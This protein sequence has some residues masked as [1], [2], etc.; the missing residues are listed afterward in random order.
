M[1]E[2][3]ATYNNMQEKISQLQKMLTASEH[4]RRVLQERLEAARQ[5]VADVKK[6]N[7]VLQEKIQGMT[8][9]NEDSDVRR[10]EIENQLKSHQKV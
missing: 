10:C 4:D 8:H 7:N 9:D 2:K 3:D 6:Q 1:S 5:A